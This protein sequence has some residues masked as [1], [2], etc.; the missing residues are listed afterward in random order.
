MD[1]KIS[2]PILVKSHLL[3]LIKDCAQTEPDPCPISSS[4]FGTR[5]VVEFLSSYDN[6]VVIIGHVFGS[7]TKYLSLNWIHFFKINKISGLT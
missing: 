3:L 4:V 5:I 1:S 7:K 2:D 6:P